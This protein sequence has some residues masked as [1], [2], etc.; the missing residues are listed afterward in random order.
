MEWISVDDRLPNE[1]GIY[2]CKGM[3]GSMSPKPFECDRLFKAGEYYKRFFEGDWETIT[4]W[5]EPMLRRLS[6]APRSE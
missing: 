5:K 2:R 4:H 6:N 3:I 1:T